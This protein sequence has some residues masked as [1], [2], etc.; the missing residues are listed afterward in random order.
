MTAQPVRFDLDDPAEIL[1]LLP[2]GYRGQFLA[3]YRRALDVAQRP[4]EFRVLQET[5]R[6]WQLRAIAYT[7]P[8]YADR[9]EAARNGDSGDFV[10]AEQVIRGWPAG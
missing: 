4:D 10:P 5:L 1:R 2:D 9:L 8:G 6:L 7:R 3:D